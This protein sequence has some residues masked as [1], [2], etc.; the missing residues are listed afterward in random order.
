MAQLPG[1][2]EIDAGIL[3]E[4]QLVAEEV[5]TNVFKYGQLPA[6]EGVTLTMD[7]A[8]DHVALEF[9]DAGIP[10]DPLEEA[11]R[12]RL[13][14]DIESAAIGGLGVHLLESLT[15]EQRYQRVDGENRLTLVTFLQPENGA[16]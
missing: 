15:D 12:A 14:E 5:V 10:F 9:C 16:S 13:G 6:G 1:E 7:L 4:M 3:E 8:D 11:K 2:A